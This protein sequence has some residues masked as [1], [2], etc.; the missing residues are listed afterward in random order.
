MVLCHFFRVFLAYDFAV[1][2]SADVLVCLLIAQ[3]QLA[4]LKILNKGICIKSNENQIFGEG[5]CP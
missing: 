2:I 5:F 3:Y 1:K 4:K